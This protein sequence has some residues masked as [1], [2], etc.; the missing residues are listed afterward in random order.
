MKARTPIILGAFIAALIAGILVRFFGPAIAEVGPVKEHFAQREVAAPVDT[1]PVE[2]AEASSP[3][4]GEA[5]PISQKPYEVAD[6]AALYFLAKNQ[7]GAE[8][9]T[10]SVFASDTGCLCLTE[11]QK[12][13]M[14]SRGGNRAD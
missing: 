12:A 3:L 2:G 11:D 4:L 1:G 9:C 7:V 5:K 10:G 6:D 14:A 13:I 8:C